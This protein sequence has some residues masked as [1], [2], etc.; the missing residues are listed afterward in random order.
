MAEIVLATINAKWIHPSLALRLLQAN[1]GALAERSAILEFALRQPLEEKVSA[2]IAER[3]RVLALSVYIWNHEATLA[4]LKALEAY[5]SADQ[6]ELVPRPII[7]LGGPEVS[8]LSDEAPLVRMA[9]WIVRGEGELVFQSIMEH[10]FFEEPLEQ[11][12]RYGVRSDRWI[13]AHPVPLDLI[14]SAYHLYTDE[15]INRKLIYVEASRGC[16]FG[17]EF[18]LSSLDRRVRTFPLETFLSDMEGLFVRGAKGFKFLDRTF[19]LD[20]ERAEKILLFFLERIEPPAYVHFEM[21]PSRFPDRLRDVLRQFPAGTLRL[22]VGIQTFTP[23][24]ARRIGRPSNPEKEQ[25]ALRF[26]RDETNAI[27]H[28]DLIAGLPGETLESFARSFNMLWAVR[29]TE[30][31]LGILKKL[32]GTP[33][34]RHDG[35]F[36]MVFDERPPYEVLE[37]ATLS[38][39]ELDRVKNF[40]RF[41]ELIVNRGHFDDLISRLLPEAGDVFSRFMELSEELLARFGKNWG[42]DRAD[43]REALETWCRNHPLA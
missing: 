5:W 13:L 24:V 39:S 9:D 25:E 8:Y 20:Y 23:E 29:P 11:L 3:P 34:A 21:V 26:L 37:T 42:I 40:A 38:R 33:I 41:W 35:P 32:P 14:R 12:D 19:N 4:L 15:D 16:P 43:L 30:I 22:E 18:C 31:Q 7:V 28:A 10:L 17:C 1:L 2:I 6:K 36:G 27:V